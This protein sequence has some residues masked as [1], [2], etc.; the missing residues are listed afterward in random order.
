M[1]ET[2]AAAPGTRG[3]IENAASLIFRYEELSF[4]YKHEDVMHLLPNSPVPAL[5]IGA[6]TGVDAQWQAER[7][8]RVVAVEPVVAFREY[9]AAHHPAPLITWVNDS[10]PLLSAV[11]PDEQQFGLIMLTAVWMH[12]SEQERIVGM[13]VLARLLA[14]GG[15]LVMTLRHGPVPEGRLMF[16]VSA[17]ETIRLADQHGLRCV[18]SIATESLQAENRRA[19][20]TWSRLAFQ[21][22]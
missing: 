18:L 20:V 5:D 3:Y 10:L 22:A 21:W 9:G 15:V 19:G 14:P 16:A 8:H 12:L 2:E 17:E 7:G 4:S 11:N 13:P 1:R 6:G